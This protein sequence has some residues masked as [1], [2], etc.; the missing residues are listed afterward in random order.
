MLA[1]GL[2]NRI[3]N[4]LLVGKS[5]QNQRIER[6]W[7][8]VTRS[9]SARFIRLFKTWA[10]DY[11]QWFPDGEGVLFCVHYLFLP[12]LQIELDIFVRTWN[13]HPMSSLPRNMSPNQMYTTY[14][15][16]AS[17][18]PADVD[19][20][21]GVD[22]D[23]DDNSSDDEAPVDVLAPLPQVHVESVH[24]NLSEAAYR[25]FRDSVTLVRWSVDTYEQMLEKLVAAVN[26][27]NELFE[28]QMTRV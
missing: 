28:W 5:T 25:I 1:H 26:L 7:R 20:M 23:Y 11:P 6:L 21:Y 18:F 16:L 24:N 4:A 12:L 15:H 14:D 2:A 10:R 22:A 3:R 19:A 9:V 8:D 17:R 27:Y 13:D